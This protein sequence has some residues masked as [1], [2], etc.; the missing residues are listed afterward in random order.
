MKPLLTRLTGI[1]TV[2]NIIIRGKS[3]GGSTDLID[4]HRKKEL[5]KLL[6]ENG[7]TARL[8]GSSFEKDRK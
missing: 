2:P 5:I 1:S 7:A 6:K 3:I 4:L 8:D